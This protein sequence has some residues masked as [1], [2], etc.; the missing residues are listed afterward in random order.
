V[1]PQ[2]AAGER[3]HKRSWGG[4]ALLDRLIRGARSVPRPAI[5]LAFA[6]ALGVVG[7][8]IG[9][10]LTERD[11]EFWLEVAK[12]GVQVLAVAVIGGAVAAA[13]RYLDEDRERRRQLHEQQ[14]AVFR[15]IVG[16][17]NEV[18]EIRRTLRSLGLRASTGELNE[19]QVNGFR[20]L[21]L[22]LNVVQLA[23]EA[24]GREVGET[25]VFKEDTVEIIKRLH[26]IED[27]LND[28]LHV[29]E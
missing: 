17:Y 16:S 1:R 20:E 3:D 22:R 29:W 10:G 14:L 21:M 12:G 11:D 26:K 27:Y 4:G 19:T 15:Q 7:I 6:G 9:K 28:V 25:D 13:W 2:I 18:K 8:L 23:F 5:A 24:L